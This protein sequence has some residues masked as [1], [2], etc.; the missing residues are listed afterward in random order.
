MGRDPNP[1]TLVM[2]LRAFPAMWRI[3]VAKAF[4]YR[5]EFLVWMLSTT[6]PLVSM[7]L[8]ASASENMRLGPEQLGRADFVAYF[9]L[10]LLVR[11]VTSSWVLW[12]ITEDIR[13]GA[14]GQYLLKPV[15]PLIRYLADQLAETP[16]RASLA[17]PLGLVVLMLSSRQSLSGEARMWGLFFVALPGAWAVHFLSMALIG[18]LA[19][20]LESALGLFYIWMGM[21]MLLSG[22]LMPLSLLPHWFQQVASVLPF[23]YILEV[24]VKIALGWPIAGGARDSAEGFAQAVRSVAV[25]YAYIAILITLISLVWRRGLRRYAAFGG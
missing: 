17:L 12:A 19:F 15:N 10:T 9:L 23:R 8:W 24:P 1:S 16:L 14:L 18:V 3:G 20:Y 21:Y 25:E 6:M 11:M 5:A 13:T 7:A 22:Y 2:S 4:A